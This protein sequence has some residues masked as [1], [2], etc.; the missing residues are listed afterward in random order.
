M[1]SYEIPINIYIQNLIYLTIFG[2]ISSIYLSIRCHIK[3]KGLYLIIILSVLFLCSSFCFDGIDGVHRW[4]NIGPLAFNSAFI[5][6]PIL[7]ICFYKLSKNGNLNFCCIF[8]LITA[9]ILFLQPDA[10]MLSAFSISLIPFY[11]TNNKT[12]WKYSWTILLVLSCISW[13]NL[14]ELEP[15]PYVEDIIVL[16]KNHSLIYLLSCIFSFIVMLMPFFIKNSSMQCREIS[17]SLGLF[18]FVLIM[19]TL[20]GNFPV[21]LIGYGVSPIVGYLLSVSYVEKN[22]L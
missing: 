8:I 5:S 3:Q 4:V 7:L 2:V 18:F 12:F 10:S 1:Y 19:S 17:I 6:L 20:F 13:I 9:V 21:P 15:V 14:D 16:A 11:Y 22:R